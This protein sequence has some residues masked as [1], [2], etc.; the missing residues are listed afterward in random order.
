MM[1]PKN[2]QEYFE[3]CICSEIAMPKEVNSRTLEF[4]NVYQ[5]SKNP[6]E[7]KKLVVVLATILKYNRLSYTLLKQKLLA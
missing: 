3:E 7:R 5:K 4:L 1:Q 6:S 2:I